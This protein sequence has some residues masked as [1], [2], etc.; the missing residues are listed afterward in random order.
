MAYTLGTT[1]NWR[2]HV[3][4]VLNYAALRAVAGMLLG[5]VAGAAADMAMHTTTVKKPAAGRAM[6]TATDAVDAAAASVKETL[7]R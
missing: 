7:D 1:N 3:F 4:G 2:T 5:A 6:Q